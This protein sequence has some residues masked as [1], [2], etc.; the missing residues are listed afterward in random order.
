MISLQIE[1]D[2]EETP[3]TKNSG[4]SEPAQL[5]G[6]EAT[7]AGSVHSGHAS[8]SWRSREVARASLG[9]GGWGDGRQ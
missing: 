9:R 4:H 2:S 6:D 5:G 1:A 3:A 7:G 8:S